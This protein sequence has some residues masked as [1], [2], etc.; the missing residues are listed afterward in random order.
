[1]RDK[2]SIDIKYSFLKKLRINS[3]KLGM[4]AHVENPSPQEVEGEGEREKGAGKRKKVP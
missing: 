1:M 4:V 2:I 3:R